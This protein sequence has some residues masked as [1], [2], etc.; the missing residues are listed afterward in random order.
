MTGLEKVFTARI[1]PPIEG[2]THSVCEL[3]LSRQQEAEGKTPP[4]R[5]MREI[6]T[7]CPNLFRG[8]IFLT[9]LQGLP[10]SR[11]GIDKNELNPLGNPRL[12]GADGV[13][14]IPKIKRECQ[15]MPCK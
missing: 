10:S 12:V 9:K 14:S 13:S 11:G 7:Q 4:S 2:Q 15:C 8:S 6:K 5:D 3:L 1:L